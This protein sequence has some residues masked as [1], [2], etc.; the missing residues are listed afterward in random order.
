VVQ[1]WQGEFGA[2]LRL[3]HGN[4]DARTHPGLEES[5]P[6]SNSLFVVLFVFVRVISWIV[7]F[8]PAKRTIHEITRIDTKRSDPQIKGQIRVLTESLKSRAKLCSPLRGLGSYGSLYELLRQS[9]TAIAIC[10]VMH[11]AHR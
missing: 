1:P 6:N 8:T 7:Y 9:R 11:T 4:A 10:M 2:A 3:G 5:V